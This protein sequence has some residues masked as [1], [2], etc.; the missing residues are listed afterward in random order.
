[1]HIEQRTQAAIAWART[2][3]GAIEAALAALVDENSFT[4]NIEGGNRVGRALQALF[5]C[6]ELRCDVTPSQ[7]YADH[8]VFSTGAPGPSILLVGHLDTVFPP[9]TFEGYR[10]VGDIARGP[11][12]LDMK[13][14]LLVA[15]FALL[16]L[17]SRRALETLAVQL[18]IVS[19]EEV[20]SPEG[21]KVLEALARNA[22]CGLVFEAGR[23]GDA[24]VTQRKGRKHHRRSHRQGRARGQPASPGGERHL[25][26]SLASSMPAQ[27]LTDYANGTTVNVGQ[28]VG[29]DARN[30]V[31]D[32]A[33]AELDLR[34]TT[35]EEAERLLARLTAEA[36]TSA[37]SVPGAALELHG[38]IRAFHSSPRLT[39]NAC[40]ANTPHAPSAPGSA[41]TR[42]R[43]S[44]E[45][46]TPTRSRGSASR[47]SMPSGRADWGSIPK[48][49]KSSFRRFCPK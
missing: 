4:A 5:E 7:A 36:A 24:I 11:G 1:M 30:T 8:R 21:Q 13:G 3:E 41:P 12:V 40:F 16:A 17:A 23:Q 10:R 33:R 14:G 29:G 6:P 49:S 20:G 37:A 32:S 38:G 42:R 26:L 43:W 31:P 19:D 34:F 2:Q 15:G 45:G 27:R 9:G 47:A 39:A 44:A 25:G 46:P 28:V 35:R 18:A 22:S 48:T